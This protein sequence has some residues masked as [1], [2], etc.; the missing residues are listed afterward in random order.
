MR[1]KTTYA[2][3]T[4]YAT[5]DGS[6]IRELMHPAVHGNKQ[7]SFAEAVIA[8]GSATLP[9]IHRTTEEIYHV[10][11][12]A[13]VM[14]LGTEELA[15]RTGDTICIVPGQ[16]H[17]VENTGSEPLKIFCCCAPPYS[18]DDTEICQEIT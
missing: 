1:M 6:L 3:I 18:H 9:H 13:G 7:V 11:E 14:Y 12:G 2:E 10:A 4:P 8:P 16:R 5:K 15:I 17:S